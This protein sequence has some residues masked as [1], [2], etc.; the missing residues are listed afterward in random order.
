MQCG[1]YDVTGVPFAFLPSLFSL[2][3]L[4]QQRIFA[5]N[6]SVQSR[7]PL[8]LVRLSIFCDDVFARGEG[9]LPSLA[10]FLKQVPA[11]TAAPIAGYDV[12]AFSSLLLGGE[13]AKKKK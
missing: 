8:D 3:A 1:T 9:S 5:C 4:D 13:K 2:R 12:V 11:Y 6:S 7:G 10:W